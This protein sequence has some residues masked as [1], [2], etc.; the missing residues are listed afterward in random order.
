MQKQ[1]LA[2]AKQLNLRPRQV[3]VWFQNRRARYLSL[4][5]LSFENW[6][7][8]FLR[9][10]MNLGFC[11][12]F[13]L[14]DVQDKIEADRGRLWVFKE[15]LRDTDKREQEVTKGTARIKSFE[16]F[17]TL[18]HAASCHHSHHVPF[19]WARGHHHNHHQS[20]H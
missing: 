8:F 20:I 6:F 3:E 1:K 16:N 5:V 13:E 17:A 18:L 15:M 10:R 11:F 7:F 12:C 9:F 14:N 4:L 19:L 2:L